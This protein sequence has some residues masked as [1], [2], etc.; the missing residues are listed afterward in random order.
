MVKAIHDILNGNDIFMFV[1]EDYSKPTNTTVKPPTSGEYARLD[2][3]NQRYT[4]GNN[5]NGEYKL[6]LLPN[7]SEIVVFGDSCG[8]EEDYEISNTVSAL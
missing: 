8:F 4:S 1:N 3:L 2:I 7:Q 6:S 5:V